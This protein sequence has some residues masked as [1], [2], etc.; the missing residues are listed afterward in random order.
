MNLTRERIRKE[1]L[2]Q[3]AR[4]LGMGKY[5]LKPEKAKHTP[6]ATLNQEGLMPWNVQV[7]PQSE[8][9]TLYRPI[10]KALS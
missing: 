9:G 3:T 4:A 5:I 7:K 10:Y 2:V 1:N 8:A 6:K